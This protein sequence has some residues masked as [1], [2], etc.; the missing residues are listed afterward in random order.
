MPKIGQTVRLTFLDHCTNAEE[1]MTCLVY[2][3]VVEV[4]DD[5]IILDWWAHID[6]KAKRVTG[7]L[8]ESIVIVRDTITHIDVALTWR[9]L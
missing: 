9:S 8:V 3:R 7:E 2:G 6:P 5:H 4:A 1:V